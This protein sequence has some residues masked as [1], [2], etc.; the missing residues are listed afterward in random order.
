MLSGAGAPTARIDR[1]H[2][3]RARSGA[4][5]ASAPPHHLKRGE[6]LGTGTVTARKKATVSGGLLSS[7]PTSRLGYG[8]NQR[9]ALIWAPVRPQFGP[10]NKEATIAGGLFSNLSRRYQV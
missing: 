8:F 3:D 6:V 4:R 1:A 5:G 10:G 7:L 2:S 9:V